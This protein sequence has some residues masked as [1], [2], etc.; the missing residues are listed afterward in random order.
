MENFLRSY[1]LSRS[2]VISSDGL[3]VLLMEEFG[4]VSIRAT[5]MRREAEIRT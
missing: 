1:Q 5:G 3:G 4:R 2:F